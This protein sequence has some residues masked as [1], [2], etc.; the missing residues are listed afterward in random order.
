MCTTSIERFQVVVK[1]EKCGQFKSAKKT[2]CKCS[3]G[4]TWCKVY[5]KR[6]GDKK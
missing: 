4:L 1:C 6:Y 3:D 5:I 2:K